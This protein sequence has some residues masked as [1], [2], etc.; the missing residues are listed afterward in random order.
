MPKSIRVVIVFMGLGFRVRVGHP[1]PWEGKLC[2]KSLDQVSCHFIGKGRNGF[3]CGPYQSRIKI[4]VRA[5]ASG[6][7]DVAVKCMRI[8]LDS[9][10]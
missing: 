7:H 8:E 3:G 9:S 2:G 1:W 5:G 10:E 4:K 6:S